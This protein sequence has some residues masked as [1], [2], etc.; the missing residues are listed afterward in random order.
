MHGVDMSI[1]S[2]HGVQDGNGMGLRGVET[3]NR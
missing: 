3:L 1:A 2:M